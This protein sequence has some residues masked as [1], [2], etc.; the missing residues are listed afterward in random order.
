MKIYLNLLPE[1]R[2]NKIKRKK[3]IHLIVGQW[4]RLSF[5]ALIF[6]AVLASFNLVLNT[7]LKALKTTR[8]LEE[9]QKEFQKISQYEKTF[10]QVNKQSAFISNIQAGHFYWS[11]A[12]SRL[13]KAV[14]DKISLTKLSA[15]NNQLSL[16]GKAKTRDDLVK[17]KNTINDFDCFDS[18]EVPVSNFIAKEN[19]NFQMNIKVS[20]NCLKKKIQ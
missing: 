20:E 14:S 9:S 13:E 7:K 4:I 6:V 17:F 10:K 16:S 2:K 5:M 18:V 8:G 12:L 11:E 3:F 15:E 19:I 1:E